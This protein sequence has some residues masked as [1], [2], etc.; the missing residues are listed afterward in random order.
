[1]LAEKRRGWDVHTHLVP[2][3]VVDE[4][5]RQRYGMAV[6]GDVLVTP[7]LR[8]AMHRITRSEV[9]SG[10]LDD[11]GLVGALVSPPPPLYRPD[12]GDRDTERWVTLVNEGLVEACAG[13]RLRPMAY[14]PVE[15]P[16]LAAEVVAGLDDSWAGVTLGTELGD[17]VYSDEVYAPLWEV[18]EDRALPGFIHPGECRDDR[19]AHFYLGNLVGNPY[20][21]AVAAAHLVFGDVM[22]RHRDLRI[23]LAHGGGATA[24]LA[25]RWERG[26]TTGRLG[27]GALTLAPR[28]AVRRFA[29]DTVVHD[30]SYLRHVVDTF[31][32]ESVEFGSDW[33]F[34]MGVDSVEA[35]LEGLSA[36]EVATILGGSDSGIR[37]RH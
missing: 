2:A 14:V 20:E 21:T 4:A 23:L 7:M 27:L 13:G 26:V 32:L 8:F 30:R 9:L 33:P 6:D 29:V 37:P 34:P 12:L 18:L 1:M 16:R 36:A 10:W 11:N 17:L 24:A 19:L 28:E 15:R 22:G 25:G 3:S 31:G 35:A 5:K